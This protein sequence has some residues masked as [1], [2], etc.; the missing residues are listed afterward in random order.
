MSLT[1]LLDM[2][3]KEKG[4]VSADDAPMETRAAPARRAPCTLT[5]FQEVT[6]TAV[7]WSL[8]VERSAREDR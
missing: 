2:L 1:M 6:L 8:E 4:H 3:K 5:T 7:M